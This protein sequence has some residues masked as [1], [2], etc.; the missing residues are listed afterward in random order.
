MSRL[1]KKSFSSS[2]SV[3]A[4]AAMC[5][6]F[7]QPAAV[8]AAEVRNYPDR[9]IR[10]IDPHAPGGGSGVI[11]RFLSQKMSEAWG[12]KIVVDNRPGATG[13]IGTEITVRAAP[14]GYTLFMSCD[15][16]RRQCGMGLTS[17]P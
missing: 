1:M 2:A 14:D 9:P 17:L 11:A 12:K 15:A 5:F 10:L 8:H 16:R 6:V 4:I 13:A 3:L 7:V